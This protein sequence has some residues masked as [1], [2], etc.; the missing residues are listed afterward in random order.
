VS[1]RIPK[2]TPEQI[3]RARAYEKRLK[4]QRDYRAGIRESL[5]RSRAAA[6][7]PPLHP[8]RPEE[9]FFWCPVDGGDVQ[10]GSRRR[11]V[12]FFGQRRGQLISPL[13]KLQ[14]E[15]HPTEPGRWFID[16]EDEENHIP[17]RVTFDTNKQNVFNI[18]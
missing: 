11:M 4:Y 8:G 14:R 9:L 1:E 10:T 18:E 13:L 5:R 7:L 12:D 15:K 2:P 6:G 17:Y 3:A 16:E